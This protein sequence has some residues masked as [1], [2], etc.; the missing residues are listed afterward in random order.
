MNMVGNGRTQKFVGEHSN[1]GKF[2]PFTFI[3][4]SFMT[5][6]NGSGGVVQF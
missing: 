6:F 3:L 5:K 1:E 2:R 4:T